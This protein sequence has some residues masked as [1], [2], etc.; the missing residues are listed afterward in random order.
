[1][2]NVYEF[3]RKDYEPDVWIVGE[4]DDTSTLYWNDNV[5]KRGEGLESLGNLITTG[6]NLVKNNKDLI[7]QSGKAVGSLAS[8]ASKISSAIKSSQEAEDL[9]LI[10]RLRDEATAKKLPPSIE[11][12]VDEIFTR[13]GDGLARF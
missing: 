9:K 2:P 6:I 5:E 10:K 4:D 13:K 8:A 3:E 11:K 7:I 12:K 1:M